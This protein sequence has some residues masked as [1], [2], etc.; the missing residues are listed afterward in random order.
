[1]QTGQNKDITQ[2]PKL[3]STLSFQPVLE[4]WKK[5]IT[6]GGDG[7]AEFY[8]NLLTKVEAIPELQTPIEDLSIL[9]KHKN[10]VDMIIASIIP[11]TLSEEEDYYAIAV[12]FSYKT[13]FASR[14]FSKQFLNNG[15]N[16]IQVEED[17]AKSLS[18]EKIS[19]AYQLILNKF[20]NKRLI[21]NTVS[22]YPLRLPASGL[23]K[24]LQLEVDT[25]FVKVEAKEPL[26]EIPD[27][28]MITCIDDMKKMEHL[29]EWLP[30]DGFTFTGIVLIQIK[31]VTEQ[32]IIH[33]IK[34]ELIALDSFTNANT[35]QNLQT[36]IENLLASSSLKIGLTPF[37][38]VNRHFVLSDQH[39]T[40]SKLFRTLSNFQEKNKVYQQLDQVFCETQD[41]LL[42]P[43]ISESTLREY[44]FLHPIFAEGGRSVI[45]FPLFNDKE[46]LGTLEITS[47]KPGKLNKKYSNKILPAVPLFVLALE[48]SAKN[49]ANEIDHAIK[50]QFTAVQSSVEWRFTE[51]ALRFISE[52]RKNED[53]KI[54]S[55]VF[56]NVYPLY[57]AIDL[58]NSSTERNRAIQ[59]DMEEQLTAV[60]GIIRK[61]R[62]VAPYPLLDAINHKIEKYLNAV[63]N[64]LLSDDEFAIHAFLK[65]EVASLFNHL[66]KTQPLVKKD[67]ENYFLSVDPGLNA[68]N[69]HR[70]EFEQSIT[71]INNTIAR[72]I[73]HEQNKAQKIF[74]H[75]FERFVTDGVDFNIYIGKSIT[76][77]RDFDNFYLKNLKIWQITTL[78]KAARLSKQLETRMAKPLQTT[79]L[80]LAHGQPISI[81]F[82]TAERKFDVD[83]A[84]N[85][86]Y[87]IIKKRIDKVHIK[88]TNER[89][90]QPGK[91]AVVYTQSN[92]AAE[93]MEYIEWLQ[94]QQLLTGEVEHFE[95]EE[96]QG[97]SGLKALRVSINLD[98][99]PEE[100]K[101]V[102]KL[103]AKF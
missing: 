25:S 35:F 88:D 95:L 64:I 83:G 42:I 59:Q 31:D 75:Y 30:L 36:H 100:K 21:G 61:A 81:S 4:T 58:R 50:E 92:E 2:F 93:Y 89:L 5:K 15:D 62:Q 53:A 78:A 11:L 1:M 98:E 77:Q 24:Y 56:E 73:D 48:K 34:N 71:Y 86:R 55:I 79:Q 80:I 44:P 85:I 27:L 29:Q 57:G 16:R 51:A 69:K 60:G 6:E 46:L 40:G 94:S 9:D 13:I 74:P 84:Y 66:L 41:V 90:T 18:Q 76:P 68:W 99:K 96:L 39:D 91:L 67:I 12:P 49:L 10:L 26:P 19:S 3:N 97:V 38:K 63:T 72:F 37:F 102:R 45:I 8:G 32:Q 101:E 54:E 17:T 52:S 70:K 23:T 103:S 28:D 22:V 7:L 20:Y 14:L 33:E 87:E 65:T 43:E 47:E 82:R